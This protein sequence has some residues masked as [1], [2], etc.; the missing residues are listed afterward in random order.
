MFAQRG[1]VAGLHARGLS[2]RKRIEQRLAVTLRACLNSASTD[3]DADAVSESF[4]LFHSICLGST[5]TGGSYSILIFSLK[6]FAQLRYFRRPFG[7]PSSPL[8]IFENSR[9]VFCSDNRH[10]LLCAILHPNNRIAPGTGGLS[11]E[12]SPGFAVQV[13]SLD[14]NRRVASYGKGTASMRSLSFVLKISRIACE[15]IIRRLSTAAVAA[16]AR[17]PR[18]S[19]R[20]MR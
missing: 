7:D 19:S 9:S 5:C 10:I 17:N 4:R 8:H 16:T 20:E 14:D 18:V 2:E 13:R 1:S 11:V 12:R 3:D 6:K 15:M